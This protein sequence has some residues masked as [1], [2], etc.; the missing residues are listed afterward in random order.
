MK[1]LAYILGYT[2]S[3]STILISILSAF[4]TYSY[5]LDQS[6][7]LSQRS[8]I[9][10]IVLVLL[11]ILILILV[12]KLDFRKTS[13][14]FLLIF[15]TIVSLILP[16]ILKYEVMLRNF[17]EYSPRGLYRIA[18]SMTYASLDYFLLTLVI[19]SGILFMVSNKIKK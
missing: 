3:I 12:H 9:S 6:T 2:G 8:I 11:S 7:F 15:I 13:S 19:I 5:H 10:S 14:S 17:P 18:Y 16:A 4:V 1:K